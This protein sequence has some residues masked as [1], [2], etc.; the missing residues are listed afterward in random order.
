[1][2][3]AIL[4]GF[5]AETALYGST[6][7]Y[8][9]G[10]ISCAGKKV[11]GIHPTAIQLAPVKQGGDGA[12]ACAICTGL[13]WLICEGVGETNCVDRCYNICCKETV[14]VAIG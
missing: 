1:M 11:S 8:R 9:R 6:G 4:P 14:V 7:C 2:E 10:I 3:V 13:Y 5:T 12:L